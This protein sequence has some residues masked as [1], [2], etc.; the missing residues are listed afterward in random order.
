MPE[1]SES[2]VNTN[3]IETTD[4]QNKQ[5]Y[6]SH[7]VTAIITGAASTV[8]AGAVLSINLEFFFPEKVI[9]SGAVVAFNSDTCKPGWKEYPLAYGRFIRGID[10]HK[11]EDRIDPDGTRPPGQIQGDTFQ[12]HIHNYIDSY[13]VGASGGGLGWSGAYDSSRNAS[14]TD[15]PTSN[16]PEKTIRTSSET[17]PNNVSLLYCEKE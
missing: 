15:E 6:K 17:R 14:K 12:S 13:P 10:K 9:S 4:A 7:I 2:E 11:K 3:Q 1:K 5:S 16:D 8:L